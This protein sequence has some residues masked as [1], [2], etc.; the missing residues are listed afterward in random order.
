MEREARRAGVERLVLLTTRTAEWFEARGFARAG[1]A[2]ASPLLPAAR[3]AAVNAARA[4]QLFVKEVAPAGAGGRPRG[5]FGRDSL[6]G[7]AP[8]KV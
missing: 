7:T 4:S 1:P 3:R 6:A 5:A 8:A 2:H